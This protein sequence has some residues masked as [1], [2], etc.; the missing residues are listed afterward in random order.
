MVKFGYLFGIFVKIAFCSIAI[1]EQKLVKMSKKNVN[2][3][4][5]TSN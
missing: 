1:R 5:V 3:H 4:V 2:N